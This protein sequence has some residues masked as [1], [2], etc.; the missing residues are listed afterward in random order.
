[1]KIKHL[2]SP[3]EKSEQTGHVGISLMQMD[4]GVASPAYAGGIKLRPWELVF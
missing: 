2:E 4:R 3:V 1:M